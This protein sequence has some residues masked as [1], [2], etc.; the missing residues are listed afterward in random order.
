MM[1][2]ASLVFASNSALAGSSSTSVK[3]RKHAQMLIRFGGD[4][5]DEMRDF[6][7]SPFDS[8]G[9][10]DD[11]DARRA[12]QFAILCHSV[13]DRNPVAQIGV[14]LAFPPDHAFDVTGLDE[15]RFYQDLTGR[16]NGFVLIRGAC[17]DSNVLRRELNH[18]SNFF[19]T[20]DFV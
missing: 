1:S 6:S 11:G 2:L 4:S 13:R 18:G 15:A 17:T 9:Q 16:T 12:D 3:R 8:L 14:R 5:D 7:R 20:N 19:G 10:L